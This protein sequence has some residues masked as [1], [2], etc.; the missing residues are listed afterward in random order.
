MRITMKLRG[1]NPGS[2]LQRAGF[3]P[4]WWWWWCLRVNP[5]RMNF[6]GCGMGLSGIIVW[7]HLH[8]RMSRLPPSYYYGKK[9]LVYSEST[10]NS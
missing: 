9:F 6:E 2:I 1:V 8:P 5:I 3:N 10:L 4:G 7:D